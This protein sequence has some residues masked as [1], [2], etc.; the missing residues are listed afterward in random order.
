MASIKFLTFRKTIKWKK[1]VCSFSRAVPLC[2][3]N[4]HIFLV[5][6]L[7]LYILTKF[8]QTWN[9]NR[10]HKSADYD[11]LSFFVTFQKIFYSFFNL[12]YFSKVN[13]SS[14]S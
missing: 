9:T 8:I 12:C 7:F 3:D 5:S 13:I 10:I 6:R 2:N 4:G 1:I 14:K 11:S